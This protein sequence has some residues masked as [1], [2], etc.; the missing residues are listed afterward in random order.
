VDRA[1]RGRALGA[2]EAGA[3]L[4]A[5]IEVEAV[6]VGVELDLLHPPRR[7]Q[8]ESK[9]EQGAGGIFQGEASWGWMIPQGCLNPRKS[10]RSHF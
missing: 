1:A 3:A 6:P 9:L 8:A 10:A 4:K 2:G 5:E 7:R